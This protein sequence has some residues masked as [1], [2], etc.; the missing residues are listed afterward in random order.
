MDQLMSVKE[1]ADSLSCSP[2]AIRRWLH[3]GRL[4]PVKVGRLTRLRA[5]DVQQIIERGL[6]PHEVS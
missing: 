6:P 1:A 2:A 4:Q 3:Q 5:T